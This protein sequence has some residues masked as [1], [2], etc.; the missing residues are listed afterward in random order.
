MNIGEEIIIGRMG[1]QPMHIADASVDPQHAVLRMTGRDTYQIED[2]GSA[3][4]VFVF[5]MRIKRKTVKG[6]TPILLGNFKTCVQQLLQDAAAIDLQAVWDAYD[7]EKRV[8]DR[9][10]MFV[11]YL[12][13]VPSILTM[14]FGTFLSQNMENSTRMGITVGLTIFVLIVSMVV[15]EKLM[16]KKNLRMAELNAE[17]QTKY[18]CPHCHRFLSFTPY[19]ILKQNKYCPNPNCNCPLP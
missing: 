8:W 17:M 6:E 3:Q 7:K 15:S 10:A 9:K 14:L 5:G 1:Q 11:N 19:Q 4:G 18:V 13:V 16:A 2:R 12:R